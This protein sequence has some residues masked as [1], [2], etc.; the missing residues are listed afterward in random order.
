MVFLAKRNH[1]FMLQ[2]VSLGLRAHVKKTR[3]RHKKS[4]YTKFNVPSL[5]NQI[6]KEYENG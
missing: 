4:D 6:L 1:V 3:E 2:R 5:I